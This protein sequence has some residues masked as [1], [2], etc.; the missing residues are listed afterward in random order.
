MEA[1]RWGIGNCEIEKIDDEPE[2]CSIVEDGNGWE[3]LKPL[4]RMSRSIC[5]IFKRLRVIPGLAL[6]KQM[7]LAGSVTKLASLGT[8]L[9]ERIRTAV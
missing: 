3:I 1:T 7:A 4:V 6:L 8:V 2:A 5:T 9:L